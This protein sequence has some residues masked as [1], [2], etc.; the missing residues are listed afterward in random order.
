L[1]FQEMQVDIEPFL[2]NMI[3]FDDKKSWL[4]LARLI[5]TKARR[6]SSLMKTQKFLAEKWWQK[7]PSMKERL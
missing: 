7:R 6:L 1:K 4:G 5:R 3:N 2:M